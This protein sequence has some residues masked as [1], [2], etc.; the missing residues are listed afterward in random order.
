MSYNYPNMDLAS[1]IPGILHAWFREDFH[2]DTVET[3]GDHVIGLEWEMQHEF[4]GIRYYESVVAD[5]TLSE[6]QE[7][8]KDRMELYIAIIIE[9]A[10]ELPTIFEIIEDEEEEDMYDEWMAEELAWYNHAR[11]MGW[12]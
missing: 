1:I 3:W 11:M 12:E 2:C 7:W 4:T 9:D 6:A 5:L 8:A 10:K